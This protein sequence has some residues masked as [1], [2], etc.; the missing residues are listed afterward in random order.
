MGKLIGR[1]V[2]DI[3]E[4]VANSNESFSPNDVLSIIDEIIKRIDFKRINYGRTY[5]KNES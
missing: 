3:R 5:K 4:G 1:T 2:E